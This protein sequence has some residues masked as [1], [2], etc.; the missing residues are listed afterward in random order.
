MARM[1]FH[2]LPQRWLAA[3]LAAALVSGVTAGGNRAA[4]AHIDAAPDAVVGTVD[5]PLTAGG[6]INLVAA[7]GPALDATWVREEYTIEGDAIRYTSEGELSA[8]GMWSLTSGE[9]AGY[10]TRFVV[11]RPKDATAFNG[12]VVLEWLNVSAGFDS[13]PDYSY[14]GDELIR[15]G[16]AWIGVSAQHVGIEGGPVAVPT[17]LSDAVR[18]GDGIKA[19][20]PERYGDLHH[21]GDAFSF[22]MF[23]Q[24][25][26][27]LRTPGDVDPLGGLNV[28][29]IIA[30][31]ES[32][33]AYA[34]TSYANGVQ[35]LTGQFDGF[36][37]HSRGGGAAPLG[38]PGAGVDMVTAVT[39]TPT[40][41]RTDLDVP[42]LVLQ[43]ETDVLG[44][45]NYLPAR[46]PDTDLVRVWEIAGTAHADAYLVGPVA[47]SFGCAR[48]VNN[49]PLHL[50]A[51]AAIR[52]VDA[53]VRDGTAPPA[54]PPLETAGTPATFAV[55]ANGNVLGGV[56]TPHV[57]APVD[58]LS[59]LP[60]D[61]TSV[62]CLL[63]GTTTP[64]PAER[65]AELYA[66]REDYLARFTAATDAA[67]AAG[68]I[69]PE[70]RDA[71]LAEAQPD[72]IARG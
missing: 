25:A 45:L 28:E 11:V 3:A 47:D 43:T 15:G 33:S 10:R 7:R 9:S 52:H 46:Q 48:P 8:D 18:A 5:G 17:P 27:T 65:L 54:A 36:L 29:R 39:G 69:L 20:D 19:I 26:R 4:A 57:D 72:R 41:I 56:R 32:Q 21:P 64:L 61:A 34:L 44:I 63:F 35:P 71:A 12:T 53:W 37:I 24:L 67:I 59:G 42:V 13:P 51:K 38:E 14:L 22:D 68:F 40:M 60:A 66:S 1:A 49:G 23:T 30:A 31:G 16:Y 70:D 62:I 50:V 58:V 55:D 2:I 6:G